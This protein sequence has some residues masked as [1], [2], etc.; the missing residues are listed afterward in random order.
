MSHKGKNDEN[1]T[2]DSPSVDLEHM[3][4]DGR[5]SGVTHPPTCTVVDAKPDTTAHDQARK[6]YFQSSGRN[7][8]GGTVK[9]EQRGAKSK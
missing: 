2:K 4:G 3:S 1:P 6:A 8:K 7:A 9:P 5:H